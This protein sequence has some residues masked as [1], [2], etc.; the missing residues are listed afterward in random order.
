MQ[1]DRPVIKRK[2]SETAVIVLLNA[3]AQRKL[4]KSWQRSTLAIT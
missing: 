2:K 3:E 4:G 1:K